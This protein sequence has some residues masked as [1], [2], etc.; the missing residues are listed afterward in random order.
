[1]ANKLSE[2]DKLLNRLS[3]LKLKQYKA[4]DFKEYMISDDDPSWKR[5]KKIL[6]FMDSM[7]QFMKN[8]KIGSYAVPF[9]FRKDGYIKRKLQI[10]LRLKGNCLDAATS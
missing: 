9:I 8:G 5:P 2:S 10:Y 6:K 7:L 4:T 1:M 3:K